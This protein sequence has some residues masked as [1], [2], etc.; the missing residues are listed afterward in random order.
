MS[1]PQ[2][3]PVWDPLVRTFHWTL[4]PAFVIAYL[5]GEEILDLHVLAGYL[6][7]GLVGFRVLWG[8]VGTRHAR[9]SDFVR[10]PATV[11]DYLR[12]LISGRPQHYL[13][14]NP[15]GGAMV[16]LLLILLALTTLSGLAFYGAKELAGPLAF[17]SAYP[18]FASHGF[19]ELHEVC[20]NLTLTLV[21]VHV[22]G[23]LVSSLLHRENLVRAMI[24]GRKRSTQYEQA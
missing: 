17:L 11:R 13:G 9:F 10:S 24:T 14:H 1:L 15:A 6:I 8:F 3:I 18:L 21:A 19:K 22:A 2:T 5:S 7:G 20:A 16:V 23:V 4:V 12:S